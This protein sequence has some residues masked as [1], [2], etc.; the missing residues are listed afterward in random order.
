MKQP[1]IVIF[2][3]VCNLCNGAVRFIIHRD[4]Q[5]K[6]VFS[7]MQSEPAK[8]LLK[9]HQLQDSTLDTVVLI[10]GG[11]NFTQSDAALEIAKELNG[12]WRCLTVLKVLPLPLRNGLYQWVA[13]N[14]YRIFGKQ[15]QCLIPTEQVKARFWL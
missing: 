14:R 5:A 10:K 6:F 9:D 11:Q 12:F 2:D 15:D 13:K 7:P 3:G 8:A 1:Y 4:P